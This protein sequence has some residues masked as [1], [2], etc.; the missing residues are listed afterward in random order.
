MSK[1][2][3]TIPAPDSENIFIEAGRYEEVGDFK[4]AYICLLAA[5]ELGNTGAQINLGNYYWDGRGVGKDLSKAASWFKEAYKQGERVGAYN[6]GILLTKQGE[7]KAAVTWLKRAISMND[8]SACLELAR[9]YIKEGM[10]TKVAIDLLSRTESMSPDDISEDEKEEAKSLLKKI[11]RTAV[12]HKSR[13]HGSGLH[14][15]AST[16]AHSRGAR[17]SSGAG[18]TKARL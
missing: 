16:T 14:K 11:A 10:N 3:F 13:G 9:L 15:T 4:S 17:P 18:K 6:L 1:N 5:A 8:G 12:S 2:S 7:N